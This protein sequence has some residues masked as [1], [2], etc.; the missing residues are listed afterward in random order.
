ML[1]CKLQSQKWRNLKH[2][3]CHMGW[4]R[5]REKKNRIFIDNSTVLFASFRQINPF[6]FFHFYLSFCIHLDLKYFFANSAK[7]KKKK[8][9]DRLLLHNLCHSLYILPMTHSRSYW[10]IYKYVNGIQTVVIIS[11][12]RWTLN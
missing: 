7:Q 5:R 3:N 11:R 9:Y 6:F 1:K 12:R 8:K 10:Y 2:F 4:K